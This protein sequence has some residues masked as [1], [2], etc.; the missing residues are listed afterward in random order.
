[1]K[2]DEPFAVVIHDRM[3]NLGTLGNGT[4]SCAAAQNDAG[5]IGRAGQ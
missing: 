5:Q 1:M 2:K 4:L 3:H